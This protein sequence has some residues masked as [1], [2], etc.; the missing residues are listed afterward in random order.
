M[1]N[2]PNTI[3]Y[4]IQEDGFWYVASKDRTPGVPEITVSAK[5]VANG[6]TTE[7]NDG[8]DFGPD[9]YNPSI[10]S[11]VPL[12][13]TSGI[14]EAINYTEGLD[15]PTKIYIKSGDYYLGTPVVYNNV[16]AI[17]IEGEI[18]GTGI[19]GIESPNNWYGVTFFITSSFPQNEYMFTFENTTSIN[20]GRLSG[21]YLSN[22]NLYGNNGS[23]TQ[24]ANGIYNHQP[25]AGH[26][27]NIHLSLLNIGYNIDGGGSYG[28]VLH[29]NWIIESTN[30]GIINYSEKNLFLNMNTFTM[31]GAFAVDEYGDTYINIK[32]DNSGPG[33]QV[34]TNGEIDYGNNGLQVINMAAF[35]PMFVF[36]AGNV[37]ASRIYV[38]YQ[39]T[40]IQFTGS[41]TGANAYSVRITDALNLYT[42]FDNN[43]YSGSAT[44]IY[45][46]ISSGNLQT[47]SLSIGTLP[48]VV[49]YE[50]EKITG[51]LPSPQTTVNGTTAGSFIASM[52]QADIKYKKVLIYLDAYENDST[53]AQTYTYPVPFSTVAE[54]TANTA[55][56]P[57]VSTSLTEF[58][59]APDTTTAYTGIIVIEGY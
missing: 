50:L 8:Y 13:Q 55:T 54:I 32:G 34:G 41:N 10:T 29:E 11:G 14:E 39:G 58:S 31:K 40:L 20:S 30:T 47:S 37:T 24:W 43:S 49:S 3:Q 7:Y 46:N 19:G 33:I 22:L 44:D 59:I 56:V 28:A 18:G 2:D 35:N 17:S 4:V 15:T 38:P 5:G 1:A 23:T 57:V 6:L 9:S 42:L 26:I 53:T 12:T 16:K 52:L 27:S 45:V 36:V 25:N 21:L 51:Y 48:S